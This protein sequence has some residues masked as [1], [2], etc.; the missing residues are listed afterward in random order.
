MGG[1]KFSDRSCQGLIMFFLPILLYLSYTYLA[2]YYLTY[3]L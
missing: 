3:I 1:D 2:Y